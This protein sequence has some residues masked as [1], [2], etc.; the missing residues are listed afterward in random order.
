MANKY[1][2]LNL[3]TGR[4]QQKEA[5]TAGGSGYAN[6]IVALGADGLIPPSM[7]GS[8]GT[9]SISATTSE[10]LTAGDFVNLYY[11]GGAVNARK[12]NATDTT[13]PAHG[14]VIAT[15]SSGN[16]VDVYTDGFNSQVPI[17][18]FT[19]ADVGKRVFLD[20]SAGVITL[21]PPTDTTGRLVQMLGTIVGVGADLITVDVE[22]TD[23]IVA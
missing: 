14:Y 8:V 9:P 13:R 21:T 1:L 11:T 16:P 4:I 17:G 22:I 10:N 3:T 20:I 23:G 5:A 19:T 15:V 7:L 18:S 2:E 6:Q 12:A